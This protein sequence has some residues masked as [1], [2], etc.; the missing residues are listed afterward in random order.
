[1]TQVERPVVLATGVG[2]IIG[3]GIVRSLRKVDPAVRVVGID[4][5][6]RSPGPAMCDAFFAKP[7]VDESDPAYLDFWIGMAARE[8]LDLVLPGLDVDVGFLDRHRDAIAATGVRLALNRP[9]LIALCADKWTLMQA[10][11]GLGLPAIPTRVDATW[12]DAVATLGPPPLLLKPRRGNGSRGIARLADAEEFR[13][14]SARTPGWMLQSIVGT[15]ADEYTV[16]VFGFGDGTGLPPIVFRRRLSATGNTQEAEVVDAPAIEAASA[17]LT[18]ALAPLGPTNYQFRLH[19]D[20]PYLLE[21]NPRFS[22]S[23]SLRTA[24]GYNEAQMCVDWF[25]RGRR[26][27]TPRIRRGIAWR[28]FEDFVVDAGPPV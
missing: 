28:Y 15:D 11:P 6:G 26:P 25:L 8:R 2:A 12:Q 9:E 4:R 7:A 16:G 21:V 10:L 27:E 17:T 18:A 23:N 22:S 13:Y 3:Q 1:M 24:F 20:T 5:S 19:G 14:W